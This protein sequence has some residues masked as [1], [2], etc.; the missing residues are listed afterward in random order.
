MCNL[1][2]ITK[3]QTAIREFTRAL[4]DRTGNLPPLP[5]VFPDT[6]APIVREGEDG[7]RELTMARWGMPSP[8]FALKGRTTDLGV[9]TNRNTS[10]PHRRRWLSPEHRCLEPLTSF[11]EYDTDEGAG[12]YRCDS[13]RARTSP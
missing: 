2:S 7:T 6:T 1:H 11:S 8:R 13:P 4:R 5:G 3:G 12:R 9:T 10:S